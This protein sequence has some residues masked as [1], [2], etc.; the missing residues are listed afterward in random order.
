MIHTRITC[1]GL[2]DYFVLKVFFNYLSMD[3]TS[4]FFFAFINQIFLCFTQFYFVCLVFFIQCIYISF[5]LIE[6]LFSLIYFKHLLLF[7]LP[8]WCFLLISTNTHESQF[9]T[10]VTLLT[11]SCAK[12]NKIQSNTHTHKITKTR[13]HVQICRKNANPKCYKLFHKVNIKRIRKTENLTKKIK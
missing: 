7:F 1:L 6:Y 10:L 9:R 2:F 3:S 13:W 12:Q 11:F 8:F 4:R 5:N